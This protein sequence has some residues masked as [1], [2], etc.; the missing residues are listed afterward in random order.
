MILARDRAQEPGFSLSAEEQIRGKLAAHTPGG[1]GG[2]DPNTLVSFPFQRFCFTV[3]SSSWTDA[4]CLLG[5]LMVQMD[6]AMFV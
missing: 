2:G 5:F 1:G 4:V 6:A 3:M